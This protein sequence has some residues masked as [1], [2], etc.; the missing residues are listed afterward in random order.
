MQLELLFDG[1]GQIPT[2]EQQCVLA[3]AFGVQKSP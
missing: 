1:F 3:M 2:E